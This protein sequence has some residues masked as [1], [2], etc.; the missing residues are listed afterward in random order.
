MEIYIDNEVVRFKN[1]IL[2][3]KTNVIPTI[4]NELNKG[5]NKL[6]TFYD[7]FLP[8]IFISVL[9]PLFGVC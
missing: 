4:Y 9:W 6:S 7:Y 3:S 8:V 1:C 5:V 2:W